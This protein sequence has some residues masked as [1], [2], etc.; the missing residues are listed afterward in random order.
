MEFAQIA[1]LTASTS[2]VEEV[3]SAM[4]RASAGD[5]ASFTDLLDL[6]K[7]QLDGL[8]TRVRMVATAAERMRLVNLIMLD[9]HFKDLLQTII[10]ES[11]TDP[12][13]FLW[14]SQLKHRARV[15]SGGARVEIAQAEFDY[16]FEYLGSGSGLVITPLTMRAYVTAA[17]ALHMQSGCGMIGSTGAGKMETIKSLAREMGKN[18]YIFNC[19]LEMDS[20]CLGAVYKGLAA[21]GAWGCMAAMDRINSSVLSI[22][23]LYVKEVSRGLR[24][25]GNQVMIDGTEVA[26][27]TGVGLFITLSPAY[28]GRISIPDSLK[29][30]FRPVA[31]A[32]PDLALVCAGILTAEGFLEAKQLSRKICALFAALPMILF[33]SKAANGYNWGMRAIK[34]LVEVASILR[35][36]DPDISEE[37]ILLRAVRRILRVQ[38]Q[39]DEILKGLVN[40][41]FPGAD[42][43][44]SEQNVEMHVIAQYACEDFG[45]WPDPDLLSK[46]AELHELLNE[47]HCTF[48]VG[49]TGIGKTT[50]WKL[51]LEMRNRL[52]KSTDE[53]AAFVSLNPK[54]LTCAELYGHFNDTSPREWKDG[55]LSK[56]LRTCEV[57]TA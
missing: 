47:R 22:S 16:A 51:A 28:T 29:D 44:A 56:I 12:D 38:A 1:L 41:Y 8:I 2:Y 11:V 23:S 13:D 43:T 21:S 4:L 53:K 50:V 35:R 36:E 46:A 27:Q 26:L 40:E 9:G 10:K 30:L 34:H 15:D 20:A 32:N 18:C 39:H 49:A 57:G 31:F 24:T 14:S 55:I 7:S 19:S 3:E 45:L 17:Q 37:T 52:C 6:Q 33:A 48:V 54:T 25:G 42:E 5:S